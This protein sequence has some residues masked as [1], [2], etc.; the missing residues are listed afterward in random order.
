MMKIHQREQTVRAAELEL[1]CAIND[2]IKKHKLTS[3]E[4]LRV[5]ITIAY[6]WIGNMAR[7]A[8]REERH[9]DS[10]KPGGLE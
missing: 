1:R 7:Y 5:V 10:D 4:S 8:I 9:G 6:E 3:G 2:T